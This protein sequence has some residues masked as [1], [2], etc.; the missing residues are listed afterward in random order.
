MDSV[1]VNVSGWEEDIKEHHQYNWGA[2]RGCM[3]IILGASWYRR[4]A[5]SR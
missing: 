5:E 4:M 1:D 2:V 3:K